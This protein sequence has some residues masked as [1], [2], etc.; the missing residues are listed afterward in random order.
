MSN[1]VSRQVGEND[2]EALWSLIHSH[3]REGHMLPRELSE[4]LRHAACFVVA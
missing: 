4:L 1:L 3:Q 2:A